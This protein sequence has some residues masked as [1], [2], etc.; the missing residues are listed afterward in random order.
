MTRHNLSISTETAPEATSPRATKH[1]RR[2][3]KKKNAKKEKRNGSTVQSTLNDVFISF[4]FSYF[5]SHCSA[6]PTLTR[7]TLTSA[8]AQVNTRARQTFNIAHDASTF[9]LLVRY[10]F[11]PAQRCVTSRPYTDHCHSSAVARNCSF[12]SDFFPLTD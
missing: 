1:S 7:L 4:Y 10:H 8:A 3:K 6:S 5:F 2:M 11:W 9:S 12:F